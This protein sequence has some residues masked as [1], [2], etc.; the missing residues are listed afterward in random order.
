MMPAGLYS[1]APTAILLT[2]LACSAAQV[3][4]G[5]LRIMHC[6]PHGRR[7][8][9]VYEG[10]MLVHIVLM[11]AFAYASLGTER[12]LFTSIVYIPPPFAALLWVN[13]ALAI[14][15]TYT[16]LAGIDDSSEIVETDWMPGI[17]ALLLLGCTPLVLSLLGS[18][19][20]AMLA[21][22]AGYFLFRSIFL[23]VLDMKSR[24]RIVSPLSIDEAL[25]RLPEGILYAN[26]EGRTM[27]VNDTM[28]RCLS[29]LGIS[30]D[31]AKA[32]NLWEALGQKSADGHG[33]SVPPEFAERP[34]AWV[35]LRIDP[36]EIR[37]FSFEGPG[38]DTETRYLA[39]RRLETDP[40]QGEIA[41]SLLGETP[42]TRVIAY[43]VT[44]E[45]RILE[46]IERT[47]AE[48]EASQG[49]LRSSMSTVQEAAENEAMLRMRGRVHDVIG[50]RL[51][52]LHRSLEDNAISDEQLEQLK[53]LLN[54]ILDDLA[55]ETHI[56]P[57][58]ELEATVSAFSLT[59][60]AIT[61]EGELPADGAYAKIMA[62]C[63]RE[64]ATN[65]VKHALARNVYATIVG[66]SARISND[67]NQPS[68]PVR[69]S[70]GLTNMRR[71]IESAGGTLD[72]T[73]EPFTLSIVLPDDPSS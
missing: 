47:N 9:T 51:S 57:A 1:I 66:N 38:F 56:A 43:D 59:G 64:A 58:D 70:T 26:E 4:H 11:A 49:E 34:G 55:A 21:I 20:L 50:Q 8:L 36:D 63:I 14:I 27:I 17:E 18:T 12:S 62:D 15:A 44:G 16:M 25:R 2:L 42:F 6:R 31:A 53:P 3:I 46:E 60:V 33:I 61:V 71:A 32:S 23:T 5:Y 40:P 13:A 35:I 69:E 29:K 65:A 24:R 30:G 28:R 37:L 48:L 41:R 10:S 7:L 39:S 19:R 72:I 52:M 22:D 45:I 68:A 67:G 54:G 73:L